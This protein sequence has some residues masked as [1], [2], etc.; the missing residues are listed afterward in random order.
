MNTTIPCDKEQLDEA[1]V[2]RQNQYAVLSVDE[3][4]IQNP[5]FLPIPPDFPC[6]GASLNNEIEFILNQV[7][8]AKTDIDL[9][10]FP[11]LGEV[12]I[13]IPTSYDDLKSMPMGDRAI[14]ARRAEIDEAFYMWV[15]ET[16]KHIPIDPVEFLF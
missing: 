3:M 1:I 9:T 5:D 4:L 14:I 10:L 7:R 2:R 6:W 16:N 13:N 8:L 15:L 12:G 11:Y